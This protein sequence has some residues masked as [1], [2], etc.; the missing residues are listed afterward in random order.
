MPLR[1]LNL[2]KLYNTRDLGG[3][4]TEDGKVTRFGVFIR[5]ELPTELPEEDI[6]Y[7]I[8]YGLIA[9]IDFRGSY[10]LNKQQSALADVIPYYHCPLSGDDTPPD[11]KEILNTDIVEHYKDMVE[12][13][14]DG[15]TRTVLDLAAKENG[16][17]LMHCAGGKDRTGIMSCLLLSI[18]GVSRE[19]IA[20]DYHLTEA[21]QPPAKERPFPPASELPDGMKLLDMS[22]LGKTPASTILA[23]LDYLDER[24]GGVMGY[25]QACGVTEETVVRIR[26]KFLENV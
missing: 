17:L 11:I 16:T 19:D 24:Y 4:P 2:K 18:A 15:W 12:Q 13:G 1:R 23:L 8:N 5:S 7:L 3:Y 10:E 14:K 6:R 25:L 22:E 20:A 26:E 21:Y 9:S